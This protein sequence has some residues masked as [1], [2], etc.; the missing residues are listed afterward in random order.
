MVTLNILN[1]PNQTSI[2]RLIA[3]YC[4]ADWWAGD[5]DNHDLLVKIIRG[6]HCFI[7]AKISD[8]II[9]MGRA[10]S[11][12]VSDAYIQDL[13]VCPDHRKQRVGT[14]IVE[15]LTDI[16]I[17]DGLQWI[18]LVAA[19]HSWKFYQKLNFKLMDASRPMLKIIS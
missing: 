14:A 5:R 16:L 11:D 4:Q 9:G 8:K 19:N 3:L 13:F 7:I 6:S 10:I 15:A 1:H 18:G 12:G 17:Q 2:K